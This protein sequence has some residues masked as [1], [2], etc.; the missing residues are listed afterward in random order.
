VAFDRLEDVGVRVT[1]DVSQRLVICTFSDE[2]TDAD[3]LGLAPLVRSHPDLDPSFSAIM[4]FSGVTA[5][6][7]STSAIEKAARRPGN[8][9]P[10]SM[11]V[12]I[13]PQDHIFGLARMSQVFAE[14]TR[15][16][17]AVVRTMEEA[18]EFIRAGRQDNKS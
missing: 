10:T 2:L 11:H 8:F 5:S 9:N 18:H 14:K 16:N 13:A 17:S 4:D 12:V 7:V 3:I 6:S 1:I 15:P